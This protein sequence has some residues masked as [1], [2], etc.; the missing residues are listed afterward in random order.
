LHP[1][2]ARRRNKVPMR[3]MLIDVFISVTIVLGDVATRQRD[4][5][6]WYWKYLIHSSGKACI[7]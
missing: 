1:W 6:F 7:C 5:D 3:A 4:L 2:I